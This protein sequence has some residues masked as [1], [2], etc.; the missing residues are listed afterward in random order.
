MVEWAADAW[1]DPVSAARE[2]HVVLGHTERGIQRAEN[3]ARENA[4]DAAQHA[5]D[6]RRILA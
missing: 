5:W 3:V 6:I 1:V 2:A 4:H